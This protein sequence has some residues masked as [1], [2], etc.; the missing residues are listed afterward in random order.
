MGE[1]VRV[2]EPVCSHPPEFFVDMVVPV[3]VDKRE[4]VVMG[5][6]AVSEAEASHE[7][8]GLRNLRCGFE[9]AALVDECDGLKRTVETFRTDRNIRCLPFMPALRAQPPY[10][11]YAV[12]ADLQGDRAMAGIDAPH[13]VV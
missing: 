1:F 8:V 9:I 5:M 2:L 4:I 13:V 12:F 3:S 10:R 6:V 7:L 11:R